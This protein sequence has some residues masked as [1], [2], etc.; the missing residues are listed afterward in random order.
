MM[1]GIAVATTVV[2]S[3]ATASPAT[4][5]MVTSSCSRVMGATLAGTP[6]PGECGGNASLLP[7]HEEPVV[8]VAAEDDAA[9]VD[10]HVLELR[11][12]VRRLRPAPLLGIVRH[13]EPGLAGHVRVRDVVA[14]KAGVE[15]CQQHGGR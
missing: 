3:A 7:Q 6:A 14:P 11:D 5:A 4:T 9:V 1:V 2:S 15:V 10:Q 13:E 8:L 12:E